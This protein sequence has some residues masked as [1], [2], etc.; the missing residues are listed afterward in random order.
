MIDG[1]VVKKLRVISD[2]RGYL[3]EMLRSDDEFFEEFGQVYLTTLYPRVVKA[4]HYHRLQTDYMTCVSGAVKLVLLDG[5]EG[6][7][8]YHEVEEVFMGDQNRVLVKIPSMVYHGFK[9]IGEGMAL[10]VN[11]ITRPYDYDNPDEYRVPWDSPD[12]FYDWSRKNG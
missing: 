7:A 12:M 9:N 11:V 4:W 3:M 10:I 1:V 2:E 6:M 5:R 8:T